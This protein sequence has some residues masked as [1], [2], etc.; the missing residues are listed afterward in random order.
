[1]T[2]SNSAIIAAAM[3]SLNSEQPKLNRRTLPAALLLL[4]TACHREQAPVEAQ[5]ISLDQVPSQGE[6]PLPSP[7]TEGASWTVSSTG[8]TIDFGKPGGKPF[9]SLACSVKAGQPRITVIRGCPAFTLQ[10]SDTNGFPPGLPK[11]IV[12]PV[13]ETVQLAPSVSG[14][15]S[16]CSPWLGT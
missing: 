2:A 10:A 3:P 4:L 12:C 13:E 6:Q 11:S 15:G 1:L 5:R 16:G 8:Q 7:D 14:E 9:V